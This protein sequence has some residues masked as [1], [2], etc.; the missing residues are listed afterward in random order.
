LSGAGRLSD[1]ALLLTLLVSLL[2]V[3]AASLVTEGFLSPTAFELGEAAALDLS[4]DFLGF[5][6][7]GEPFGLFEDPLGLLS[8]ALAWSLQTTENL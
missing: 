2:F 3:P 4:A 1:L 6:L 7:F 8:V 5:E